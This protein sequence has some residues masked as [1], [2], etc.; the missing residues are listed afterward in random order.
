MIKSW[1][2][3][4]RTIFSLIGLY[5]DGRDASRFSPLFSFQLVIK[6]GKFENMKRNIHGILIPDKERAKRKPPEIQFT[7]ILKRCRH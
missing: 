5:F 4:N 6:A 7:Q 3:L 2:Q 1:S